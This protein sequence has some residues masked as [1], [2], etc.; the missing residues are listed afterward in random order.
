MTNWRRDVIPRVIELL[1][2]YE[3]RPTVRGMFYRLY[4]DGVLS[5][6]I[7]E[8]KGLV[9]A[10]ATARNKKPGEKGYID[11][12]AFSDAGRF[13]E[14]IYDTFVPVET[15]A[16]GIIDNLKNITR[17]Y[18]EFGSLPIW[19]RQLNYVEVMIEKDAM[20]SAFK[21]M[22]P[23][24]Y[25]RIVP[26][27]GWDSIP[28]RKSNIQRL[29]NWRLGEGTKDIPKE[30]YVLY[31]GDYDPTGTAMSHKIEEWLQP[32]GINF[33]RVA[34]NHEH[35]SSYS[36]ERFRNPD[37]KVAAKLRKDPNNKRFKDENDGQLFQ[38]ELDV[39]EKTPERFKEL[40]LGT[41]GKYYDKNIYEENMRKF[42]P[43]KITAYVNKRVKFVS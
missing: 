26:N 19:Y 37:P 22:F 33:V 41:I 1:D 15:F 8:Y 38:I 21:S 20:R 6:T 40:V 7:K 25:V 16:E 31:F 30:V 5:N 32:H 3:Y 36:L 35:I 17:T 24:N 39:L 43:E 18:F 28:Y 13:I 27:K 11:P 14:D 12:F 2:E 9:Q 10:L 34:L 29:N 4:N 23:P 42:I